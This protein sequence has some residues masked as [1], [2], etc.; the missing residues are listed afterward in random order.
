MKIEPETLKRLRDL[1]DESAGWGQRIEKIV[2][3]YGQL[4]PNQVPSLSETKLRGLWSAQGFARAGYELS[5]PDANQLQGLRTMTSLLADRRKSLGD[6]FC[7]AREEC[8]KFFT[9]TQPAVILRTLL[10]LEGGT[11]GSIAT[12]EWTN[13]LLKEAGKPELDFGEADSIT[14]ALE[15]LKGLIQKW[16]P[17]VGATKLGERARIPFLLCKI[18]KPDK[19]K[20]KG[21]PKSNIVL[22]P[23][24]TG[25]AYWWLNANPQIW[26]FEALPIGGKETYSSHNEKGNK[27]KKYKCFKEVKPGDMVVGYVTSPRREVVAICKITQG[28][29]PGE[30]GDEFEFEK[31][32]ELL[33]PVSYDMLKSEPALKESDL[34]N[35]KQRSLFKLT[36]KEYEVICSMSDK[37]ELEDSTLIADIKNIISNKT[38]DPT[39]LRALVNARV[40]QGKYGLQVRKIWSNRCSVTRSCTQ[41]ALEASHIK[42]W[43]DSDD[44]ERLDPNNGLLLTANLHRLFDARLISFEDSGKMLVSSKLSQTEQG[45]FG[46]V[47]KWLSQK[48]SPEIAKYLSYHRTK[49]LI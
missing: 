41:A 29:H 11:F 26:D 15:N 30:H 14:L 21:N 2:A 39:T 23:V 19:A 12:K 16:A 35:N 32:W 43:A 34:L 1:L 44:T 27:R 28:L 7:G 3:D 8:K 36:E 37:T 17:G 24:S 5:R 13:V 20:T 49:F 22:P 38:D 9:K 46:L 33:K 4:K 47:G 45:I 40:G 10:I 42:S 31:V 25:V 48:P 18:I 6:R